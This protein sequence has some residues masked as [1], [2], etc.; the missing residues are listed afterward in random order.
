ME[1]DSAADQ[2]TPMN[3]D[4][5]TPRIKPLAKKDNKK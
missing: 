3:E 1:N 4:M 2:I 5:E